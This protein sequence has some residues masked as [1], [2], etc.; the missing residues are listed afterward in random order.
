MVGN[1]GKGREKKVREEIRKESYGREEKRKLG[2][3]R[4][5]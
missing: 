1:V 3:G 2:T 4:G 5:R